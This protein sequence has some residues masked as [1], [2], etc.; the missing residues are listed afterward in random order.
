MQMIFKVSA[1]AKRLK[2]KNAEAFFSRAWETSQQAEIERNFP[3][4]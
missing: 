2:K 3:K 4:E 1:D